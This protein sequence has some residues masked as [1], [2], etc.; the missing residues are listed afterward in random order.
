[1][2]GRELS[3]FDGFHCLVPACAEVRALQ[4]IQFRCGAVGIDGCPQWQKFFCHDR[5]DTGKIRVNGFS[6]G[7]GDCARMAAKSSADAVSG[8][9]FATVC[10][11]YCRPGRTSRAEL[12][13]TEDM[14][15]TV[16][17]RAVRAAENDIAVFSISSTII[18]LRQRSAH[19]VQ[20]FDLKMNTAFQTRLG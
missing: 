1:M 4:L 16:E 6:A 14:F 11:K 19:L 20:M 3:I 12:T 18:S 8:S 13:Y 9:C 5:A 7:A 17:D 2:Q 10:G 15:D